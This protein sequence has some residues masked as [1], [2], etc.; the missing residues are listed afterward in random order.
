MGLAEPYV[1]LCVSL[2]DPLVDAM[3]QRVEKIHQQAVELV[4]GL[5]VIPTLQIV[6]SV[7][8]VLSARGASKRSSTQ[9]TVAASGTPTTISLC[10]ISYH[11]P[12]IT[13]STLTSVLTRASDADSTPVA[14]AAELEEKRLAL[15]AL[16]GFSHTRS[17][18]LDF[19][20][21][22]MQKPFDLEA[23]A[24]YF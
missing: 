2:L 4:G 24:L 1:P 7:H 21:A 16:S 6:L 20:P 18:F 14:A 10:R 5:Q 9:P 12:S 3:N 15:G 17:K 11:S 8:A 23:A 13:P 22:A 19:A